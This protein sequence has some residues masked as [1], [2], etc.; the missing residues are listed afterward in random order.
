MTF[1]P[2]LLANELLGVGGVCVWGGGG[3]LGEKGSFQFFVVMTSQ[4]TELTY[5]QLIGCNVGVE[6]G[7][8]A[9]GRF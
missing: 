4:T 2:L 8:E 1:L 9:H 5:L 7:F 6:D 3:G